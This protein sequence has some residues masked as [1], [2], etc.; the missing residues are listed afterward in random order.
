MKVHAV[1]AMAAV[2]LSGCNSLDSDCRYDRSRHLWLTEH[3]TYGR[4]PVSGDPV[5]VTAAVTRSYQGETYYF[6]SE[7]DAREFSTSPARF[8]YDG[9]EADGPEPA[10]PAAR[11][12]ASNGVP[13]DS[14]L[15]RAG[16]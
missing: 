7:E 4:D 2:A 16:R 8:S 9:Q 10:G 6:E 14:L 13:G 5:W 3:G 15:P 12:R 1:L 11:F